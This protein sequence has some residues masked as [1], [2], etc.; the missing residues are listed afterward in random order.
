[1]NDITRALS[2]AYTQKTLDTLPPCHHGR[3]IIKTAFLLENG[4]H[5]MGAEA[6]TRKDSLRAEKVSI[7]ALILCVVVLVS[8]LVFPPF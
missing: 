7:L 5:A 2:Q 6:I 3:A 8:L 1:M 4:T